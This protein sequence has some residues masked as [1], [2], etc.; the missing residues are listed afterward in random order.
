MKL[1]DRKKFFESVQNNLKQPN[2]NKIAYLVERA[3]KKQDKSL[4]DY[5][6]IVS[7]GT[8]KTPERID[9]EQFKTL[10]SDIYKQWYDKSVRGSKSR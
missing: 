4:I 9:Y 2:M 1:S 8:S 6:H 7:L 5:K 3:I 10:L